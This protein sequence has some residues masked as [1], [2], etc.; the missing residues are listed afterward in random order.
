[1][2]GAE[3][4]EL[5]SAIAACLPKRPHQDAI[6]HAFEWLADPPLSLEQMRAA[7]D[8]LRPLLAAAP[9][10]AI[11]WD[12]EADFL[13]QALGQSGATAMS[14][15]IA[16]ALAPLLG[17]PAGATCGCV[18]SASAALAW[19]LAKIG[20]VRLHA[21]EIEIARLVA[22][23]AFAAG[24]PMTVDRRNPID[25]SFMPV[26]RES[27]RGERD[28]IV[29]E[30]AD[31]IVSI[32][33]FGMRIVDA[34][35]R[36]APPYEGRQIALLLPKARKSLLTLIPDGLLF[37]EA[38][39]DVGLR[40]QLVLSASLTVAS[41]PA[42]LWGRHTSISTS[43]LRIEP[44]AAP[45]I[46]FV[47]LRR[48]GARS[49]GRVQDRLVAQ[50][51]SQWRTLAEVEP[52]RRAVIPIGEVADNAWALLPD[53][54]IRHE[55]LAALDAALGSADAVSLE[56]VAAIER[57]KAPRPLLDGK[58]PPA[59]LCREIAPADIVDGLV[60]PPRRTVAF[61]SDEAARA[62]NVAVRGGDLVVS[63]KGNVGIVGQVPAEAD[64][65]EVMGEPWIVSQSLAIVRLKP[66]A[67]MASAD[68]LAAIVTA[69][70]VR[71]RLE[72]LSGGSIIATLP[73]SALRG[74]H[75]PLPPPEELARADAEMAAIEEM[76]QDISRR[77]ENLAERRRALWSQLWNVK[78][79]VEMQDDA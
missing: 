60:R 12:A 8:A 75:I 72:S 17:I 58:A 13:F 29:V 55:R 15:G 73:M 30:D 46:S 68:A 31:Y 74:L 45:A 37:R 32:P 71:E 27:W 76:R 23:L 2:A 59:L 26:G 64:L 21:S 7:A 4:A 38:R 50:H 11:D 56:E 24:R 3:A 39:S 79:E 10:A 69:P 57:P 35:G 14:L 67:S 28:E 40:K 18:F 66:N 52:T 51:L 43:L 25:G 61:D 16:G 33:P 9:Q 78:I 19:E 62:R 5:F 34:A 48:M 1:V 44:G 36:K 42:G 6:D 53:R 70:F 77:A 47:D 54:Y 41:L 49:V 65:A 63:I 20:D 22:V